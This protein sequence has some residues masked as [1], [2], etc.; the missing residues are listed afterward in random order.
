MEAGGFLFLDDVEQGKRIF[1]D[2]SLSI[3]QPVTVRTTQPSTETQARAIICWPTFLR[4]R[5][6][7]RDLLGHVER[8]ILIIHRFVCLKSVA[9]IGEHRSYQSQW[10][11]VQHISGE[12]SFTID[13]EISKEEYVFLYVSVHRGENSPSVS[14]PG[15]QSAAGVCYDVASLN[16]RRQSVQL[17]LTAGATV[18]EEEHMG[19]LARS[20]PPFYRC[21]LDL[22]RV[23]ASRTRSVYFHYAGAVEG[24]AIHQMMPIQNRWIDPPRAPPNTRKTVHRRGTTPAVATAQSS[25]HRNRPPARIRL[26]KQDFGK[27][28]ENE[29]ISF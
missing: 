7:F 15:A 23:V 18:I 2:T 19:Q 11:G 17:R 22:H 3:A 8:A 28:M 10:L 4:E 14:K 5:L 24:A 9:Y 13:N 12:V 1:G 27:K 20:F 25:A 26:M 16:N 6:R 21:S 29:T